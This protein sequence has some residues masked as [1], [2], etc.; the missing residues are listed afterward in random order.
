M[1]E[2]PKITLHW[3]NGSR[4]NS[5]LWLLEELELS[6]D[7]KVYHRQ[8]NM[9]A[10]PEL[11]KVHPLGKSPV[12]TVAVPG[13]SEPVVLAESGF[14]FQYLCDHFAQGKTIVPKRWK[15]GQEGKILGETE[16]WMRYSY[17]LH[18]AEGSFMPN[19]VMYLV[20]SALKS[21]QVPFF[22]RPISSAIANR[23]ISMIVYP[24]IKKH[25]AFLEKQLETSGGD[26]L[27]GPHLTAADILMSYPLLAGKSGFDGMGKFAR[28]TAKESFPKV[29]E[30]M[31]RLEAQ[32]GWEKAVQKTKDIDGDHGVN[33]AIGS[34]M[35]VN[36]AG[37]SLFRRDNEA[38]EAP[39]RTPRLEPQ[40]LDDQN[41]SPPADSSE[42]EEDLYGED[43]AQSFI[44]PALSP[45]VTYL[46]SPKTPAA[47]KAAAMDKIIDGYFND[48]GASKEQESMD[49]VIA[50]YFDGASV[51]RQDSSGDDTPTREEPRPQRSNQTQEGPAGETSL[52]PTT[53]ATALQPRHLDPLPTPWKTGPKEIVVTSST[54]ESHKPALASVFSQSRHRRSSSGGAE[55][56]RRLSKALPSISLPSNFMP[57]RLPTPSFFSSG[58]TS[59]RSESKDPTPR[60]TPPSQSPHLGHSSHA[61]TFPMIILRK[62]S[63]PQ[64]DADRNTGISRQ[65]SNASRKSLGIRRS[66][67]DDSMLYH[68][69]SRMSSFGDDQRFTHV[70]EQVNSRF[71]AIVDSFDTPSFKLPSMPSTLLSPLKKAEFSASELNLDASKSSSMRTIKVPRDP[72]D[73]VLEN[74][75]GDLVIMGGYRGSILRSAEPPHRQLW[76]PMKVG[77]KVRKVNLEVGL[78]PEDE[79]NMEKSIIP[80]GMLKNIGPVDISKRLFKRVRENGDAV[81]LNEKVL[82]A[83]VNFTLRTTWVFLP[84]DGYCFID[85][86][87]DEEYPV[88]F[89]DTNEWV[90]YRL[91]PS[92]SDPALPPFMSKRVGSLGSFLSLSELSISRGRSSSDPAAKRH[93]PTASPQRRLVKDRSLAPQMDASSSSTEQQ[94][95]ETYAVSP[96]D[97]SDRSKNLAYLAR[98][99]AETKRFRS[100][101]Q[102]SPEHQAANAYPPIAVIYGK[103]IPTVFAARVACR[104]AI[105]CQDAYDNLAFGSGDGVVLAKQAMPPPGYEIAKGGRISTD[106]GHISILG[107]LSAVGHALQAVIRGRAK[108]IGLGADASKWS[109]STC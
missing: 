100:E 42:G 11:E 22:V 12:I 8:S 5:L 58:S 83:H 6:Y 23:I 18:Y 69:L 72:L 38:K 51:N 44:Q 48:A 49:Q 24:N 104:E 64:Q 30:Y 21:N 14:I 13:S 34:T 39:L 103:E 67:S 74:L 33:T 35:A 81:L 84:E 95:E 91:C 47:E 31:D 62:P 97:K 19:L 76:V 89:Y 55:A 20:L 85:K 57:N 26:F 28:G 90:K 7:V 80:S 102:H 17:L 68:S 9:L 96:K 15:E 66:T 56:L 1:A 93:G 105:P 88:D 71:K 65:P 50:G 73:S 54:S 94:Q 79:E 16:A 52:P 92:V 27:T 98:T 4:A 101:L 41:P 70:R 106:K 29:H 61:S 86:V 59:S 77:L 99:L 36:I 82:T 45:V 2:Q 63:P 107:D 109:G 46:T 108:G 37:D 40:T 32:A 75:T 87:T 53:T 60:H 25:L 3:L 43:A 78:N 10:P